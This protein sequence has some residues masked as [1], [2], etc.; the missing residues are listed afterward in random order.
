MCIDYTDIN[1]HCSKDPFGLP[2]ID[3]IVDS[4]PFFKL[5]KKTSK[6]GKTAEADEAFQ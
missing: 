6:F 3:Q 2:L 1:K 4:T 5:L